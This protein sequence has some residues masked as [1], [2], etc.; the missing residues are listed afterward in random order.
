MHA[1]K[2]REPRLTVYKSSKVLPKM[3]SSGLA[4]ING[5]ERDGAEFGK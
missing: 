5:E 3:W 1:R 2:L 4:Y